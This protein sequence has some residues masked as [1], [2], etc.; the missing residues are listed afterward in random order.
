MIRA[1]SSSVTIG[2]SSNIQDHSIIVTNVR[3]SDFSN[4]VNIGDH[5]T[6]GHG[7]MLTSCTIG[8][9]VLIGQGSIIQEGKKA[10]FLEINT[11][12]MK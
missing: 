3:K 9:N 5:V 4:E 2:E 7:A 12:G 10:R 6:V 1:D 11:D 8:N